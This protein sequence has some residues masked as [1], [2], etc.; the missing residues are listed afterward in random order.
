[1]L[2]AIEK[3][4]IPDCSLQWL[5]ESFYSESAA[6]FNNLKLKTLLKAAIST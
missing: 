5:S 2:A 1:V 4:K 3:M 6:N